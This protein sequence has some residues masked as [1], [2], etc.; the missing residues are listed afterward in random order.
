MKVL[1]QQQH[2]AAKTMAAH[3]FKAV[4]HV[5]GMEHELARMAAAPKP[6]PAAQKGAQ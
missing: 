4:E 1:G 6:E 5:A 2:D 3:H